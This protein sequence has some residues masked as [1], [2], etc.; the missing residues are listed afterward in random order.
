MQDQDPEASGQSLSA[1]PRDGTIEFSSYSTAQLEDLKFAIDPRAFPQNYARLCAELERR[2]AVPV[3]SVTPT[4]VFAGRFTPSDGLRGWF[5][6][7]GRRSPVY[8]AGTI[9]VSADAV[10]L[11]GW[12]RTWLGVGYRTEVRLRLEHVRNVACD[13]GFVECECKRPYHF[14][15]RLRFH[16]ESPQVA[17]AVAERLPGTQTKKWEEIREFNRHLRL[18][19]G[20]VWVTPS[21]VA[22]NLIVFLA[23]AMVSRRLGAF[24]PQLV[25]KWGANYGPLT[26]NGEWWRTV[27]ALFLHL[28][29]AHVLLNMWALW[30]VGRLTERL[31]GNWTL[32]FLYLASGALASLTSIAWNPSYSSVGASGAIFGVFGAFLAF[33]L[34]R[35]NRVPSQIVRANWLS[36][37]AFVVFNLVG[38]ILQTGID[39][40]AHVGGLFA[41]FVV[42]WVLVRPLGAEER[43]DFPW[44]QGFAG[45]S[46]AAALAFASVWYVTGLGMQLMPSE[47]YFL[48]RAWYLNGESQNLR[49]WQEIAI[50]A[51]RGVISDAEV[52]RQFQNDIVPFWNDADK[53]LKAEGDQVP[54]AQS[55]IAGLL[56]QFVSLRLQWST[57]IAESAANPRSEGLKDLQRLMGETDR[58]QA[59]VERI[60]IRASLAHRPRALAESRP[61]IAIRDL[62]AFGGSKCVHSPTVFGRS[63][64]AT[65][66]ASDAPAQKEK[67]GC[68]AQRLFAS[69]RYSELDASITG[70][71]ASLGDLSDGSSTLRGLVGGLSNY[72]EYGGFDVLQLL[73]RTADWRRVAP[74]SVYPD[75]VE[76]MIFENWAWAARGHGGAKEV[77]PQAWALFTHR[78]EMAAASLESADKARGETPIWYELSL[79]VG[80][81]QSKPVNELRKIFNEG[82]AKFP[83]DR[84]LYGGML[85]IL[86]PRW[87]GSYGQVD[88]FVVES[89]ERNG[90][91]D[92]EK[93]A[94][95]Y[96]QYDALERDDIDIFKDASAQWIIMKSGFDGLI[97][98]YRT[99]DTIV[100]GF[101]RFACIS[102]DAEK[103]KALKSKL[104]GHISS[105]VWTDKVSLEGCDKKFAGSQ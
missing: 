54:A 97:D 82:I 71:T 86:M 4:T 81:D 72:L 8:G 14:K 50:Q 76:A 39:N 52:A 83:N 99:S 77:T 89:S 73:G 28:N 61:V 95:L 26:V 101:A 56:T 46:I 11:H 30:N 29:L 15:Q 1:N 94:L 100:N 37:L 47:Q 75:L 43:P 70:A 93:Y 90:A 13:D 53:R 87:F 60:G 58:V 102:G 12:R 36:T 78:T 57:A 18:R 84:S 103:Y 62:L 19:A 33:L 21:L 104:E 38:G 35:G 55:E 32:A 5:Q 91:V 42:G 74:Q 79:D 92:P 80:L 10:V 27:T 67:A 16:A 24:D 85:R 88:T 6:A 34:H 25:F 96:W 66:D 20:R 63:P 17:R 65:D 68:L 98:H 31:Y 105:V 59:R 51:A 23:L 9:E 44:R 64:V 69:R 40:A 49:R 45:L 3:D 2:R 22:A 7:K 48:D 41:G